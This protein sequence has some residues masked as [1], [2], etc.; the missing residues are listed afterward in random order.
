M[1]GSIKNEKLLSLPDVNLREIMVL[2]PIVVLILWIG[3]YPKSFLSKTEASVN[4]LIRHIETG[5]VIPHLRD[6]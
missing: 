2:V 1:F 5:E 6:K 3:L 4:Q